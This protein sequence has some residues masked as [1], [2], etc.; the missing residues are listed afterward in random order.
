MPTLECKIFMR[1]L[2]LFY[3][4]IIFFLFSG[5]GSILA[6]SNFIPLERGDHIERKEHLTFSQGLEISGDYR[7]RTSKIHSGT[8]MISRSETNSPE[9][10]SFDQDIRI[11]LRSIVHRIISLNLEIAT[12][13]EPYYKSDIRTSG[14]FRKTEADSQKA[15]IYARQSFLEINRNPNEETKIGKH[16]INIGDRKGKVFYGILSGFSQRCK[17]GT[18][19]YEIGGMKLSSAD[20]DWLYFFSL[21]YPFWN[22]INSLGDVIDSFRIEMFR[23]KYT[24]HDVPLG[25]NNV[26]ANRLS[27]STISDLESNGFKTGSSCNDSLSNFAVNS[28][29]KPIYFNAHEQE[30]FGLRI[31]WETLDWSIYADIISNQGNRNY[32]QYDDRHNLNRMKI[33]GR[34]AEIELSYKKPGEKYTLIGM[35]ASGDE[36]ISDSGGSGENYLRNIDGYYEITTGTYK[37]NL[38]YFNGGSPNINSGTGLGHSIN[39]TQMGGFRVD[40]DI[41]ETRTTYRFGLYELKRI[42]PVLN[43]FGVRSS[44][45]GVELDNTLSMFLADHAKIDLDLNAFKPGSAFS[46]DDH[47]LPTGVKDMI[48]HFAG[49]ITYVF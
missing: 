5:V 21:D 9:E 26:P 4:F 46:Y 24:E 7:F 25:L 29:C 33:S 19:C 45:I 13:Q 12:N 2:S 16:V 44:M 37:G 49:R 42:K 14:S 18:W 38:F 10:F 39:N 17:A 8:S 35:I 3:L 15:N 34:A 32:F 23:I 30:Y 6:Q 36:Q 27:S 47:I 1:P 20:G 40:Y 43:A 22:D 28:E 48:F 41:P 11:K 31:Q